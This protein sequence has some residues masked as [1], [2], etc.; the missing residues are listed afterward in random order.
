MDKVTLEDK[1]LKILKSGRQYPRAVLVAMLNTDD[2]TVRG[3]IAR[4]R[5]AGEIIVNYSNGKGYKWLR[6]D[7]KNYEEIKSWLPQERARVKQ[8]CKAMAPARRYIKD[9]DALFGAYK[10]KKKRNEA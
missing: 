1:L 6:L 2:R 4:L 10:R 5:Q 8:S 7:R 3:G 9:Y